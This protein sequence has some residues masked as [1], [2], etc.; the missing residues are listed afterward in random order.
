MATQNPRTELRAHLR[1]LGWTHKAT[2]DRLGVAKITVTRWSSGARV[3]SEQVLRHLRLLAILQAH[4]PKLTARWV[5]ESMKAPVGLVEA[6][7]G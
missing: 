4:R 1:T 2:A 5:K 6:C 7:D 3:P